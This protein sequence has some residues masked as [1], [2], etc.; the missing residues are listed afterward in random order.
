MHPIHKFL[1]LSDY[2][3]SPD[4]TSPV[5]SHHSHYY[6]IQNFYN[7]ASNPT[8]LFPNQNPKFPTLDLELRELSKLEASQRALHA[9]F[10]GPE[11]SVWKM[12]LCQPPPT[13]VRVTVWKREAGGVATVCEKVV[14]RG[15]TVREVLD[16]VEE[17]R[18]EGLKK[19][20][21]VEKAG[22]GKGERMARLKRAVL[23]TWENYA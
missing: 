23:G 2:L 6:V 13:E 15:W 12:Y 17:A 21:R 7:H 20:A 4:L 14:V 22:S 3:P 11:S 18:N 9:L 5:L 16:N 19:F 8:L 1:N 10:P